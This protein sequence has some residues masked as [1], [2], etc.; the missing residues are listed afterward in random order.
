MEIDSPSGDGFTVTVATLSDE[1]APSAPGDLLLGLAPAI[2][3]AT[4]VVNDVWLKG[5]GPGWVTGK[6]S[7][8]AG[9]F[10]LPI[11]L[12][13]LVEVARR[14]RGP[15][16]QATSRLIAA[17][18]WVVAVGFAL[19]KTLPLVAS[20]YALGIG[21]LRWPVL[22]LNAL[23]SGQAPVGP[24]PIEVIVDP[25]DIVALVVVPLAYLSMKRR[26]Q[27]LIEAR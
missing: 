10:L 1:P 21:I 17:I 5:R 18:C 27:P 2:A 26:R 13:S 12:V 4:L 8:F 9:L 22:A 23:A 14:F 15:R 20:T 24:T 7:D 6:L 11:V 25:T 3:L 16:W 19:V